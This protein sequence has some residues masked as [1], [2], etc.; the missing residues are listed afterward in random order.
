M[1]HYN[2][3]KYNWYPKPQA[4]EK[5][6][7]NLLLEAQSLAMVFIQISVQP[8]LWHYVPAFRLHLQSFASKGEL[9]SVF[10]E[11]VRTSLVQESSP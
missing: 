4:I 8:N 5:S 11:V 7:T 1:A 2:P 6:Q 9:Q 3:E 10:I